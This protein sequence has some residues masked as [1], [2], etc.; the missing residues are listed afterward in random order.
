MSINVEALALEQLEAAL[1]TKTAQFEKAFDDGCPV[2]DLNKI[3]K[4]LKSI[5][6]EINLRKIV[7][8][9]QENPSDS[10]KAL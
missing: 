4:E 2:P 3:Y 1:S 5:Q 6:I 7:S 9:S 10:I 8:T